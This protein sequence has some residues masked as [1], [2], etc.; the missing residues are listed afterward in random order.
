MSR[1]WE[2]LSLAPHFIK[3]II[4]ECNVNFAKD[5]I[6]RSVDVRVCFANGSSKMEVGNMTTEEE[7][8]LD[9][10]SLMMC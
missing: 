2:F 5:S 7:G 1:M 6:V 4:Y 9:S 3:F 10:I 8:L